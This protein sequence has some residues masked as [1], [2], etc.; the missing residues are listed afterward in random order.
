MAW[1]RCLDVDG[2]GRVSLDE[3]LEGLE[4]SHLLTQAKDGANLLGHVPSSRWEESFKQVD[5]LLKVKPGF[6]EGWRL[7]LILG[8]ISDRYSDVFAAADGLLAVIPE[9]PQALLLSH[10]GRL[11][12][13]NRQPPQPQASMVESQPP[14]SC[15]A[16]ARTLPRGA[17]TL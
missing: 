10:G 11:Y 5:A 1:F 4:V 14:A 2:D 3:L 7:K 17:S 12:N 16:T 8:T 15:R 13:E 6:A 9:D